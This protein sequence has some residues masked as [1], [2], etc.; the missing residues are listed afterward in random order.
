MDDELSK[1]Y[2]LVEIGLLAFFVLALMLAQLVVNLRQ[3]VTLSEPVALP[4]SGVSVSHPKGAGWESTKSWQYETDNSLNLVSK[5]IY[6]SKRNALVEV[7]WRYGLCCPAGSAR[8][9][10]E[11]RAAA[12]SATFG[13]IYTIQQEVP[14]AYAAISSP[15]ELNRTY[16]VGIARLDYGRT[17]ELQVLPQHFHAGNGEELFLKLAGSLRYTP[18]PQL[19][20][21]KELVDTLWQNIQSHDLL[22]KS[23]GDD[24]FVIRNIQNK[25][26]GYFYNDLLALG[27]EQGQLRI[28][29][30]HYEVDRL[31]IESTLLLNS[32]DKKFMWKSSIQQIHLGDPRT[33][34]IRSGDDG[35][36]EVEMDFD[37]KKR[38]LPSSLLVPEL[39]IPAAAALSLE[40]TQDAVIVDVLASI[41][42]VVPTLIREI[43]PAS[44]L[45]KSE[46][47]E[48]VVRVRF[49]NHPNSFE[50][51]Y[52]NADGKIIGRLEQQA[53]G[54]RRLWEPATPDE[55]KRLFQDNFSF[56]SETVAMD[57]Y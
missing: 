15:G 21:G 40:Q 23:H 27:D 12:A 14:M 46:D 29:N 9:L 7:R 36:L 19:L 57:V 18:S 17:I 34:T 24:A 44:A 31:L 33:Y 37:E 48:R 55:L 5:H 38:F 26:I 1:R 53:T 32:D 3:R 56:T 50:E 54:P 39:L 41:G 4:G 20:G 52:F 30:H 8:E 2:S 22:S 42:Y 16:Y 11:Q 6:G 13:R 25:P 47:V 35:M 49:L 43:E 10:L 45:A 28:T 51:L